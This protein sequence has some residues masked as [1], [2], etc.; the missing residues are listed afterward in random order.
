MMDIRQ[1]SEA[2]RE[3][4]VVISTLVVLGVIGLSVVV[5]LV[6]TAWVRGHVRLD[7]ADPRWW[8]KRPEAISGVEL[9]PFQLPTQTERAGESARKRLGAYGWAD[10]QHGLVH[11]PIDVA[12]E[13]YLEEQEHAP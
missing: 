5:T 2:V 3:A 11:I 1:D 9:R 7:Q 4:P 6:F 12:V 13:L 10:Q 8:H